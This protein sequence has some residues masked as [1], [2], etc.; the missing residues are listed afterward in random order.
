[1]F[2]NMPTVIP[3]DW[4]MRI[5]NINKPRNIIPSKYAYINCSKKQ[6]Y[7]T[8]KSILKN[9]KKINNKIGKKKNFHFSNIG[10]SSERILDLVEKILLGKN[11]DNVKIKP[12]YELKRYYFFIKQVTIFKNSFI[13]FLKKIYSIIRTL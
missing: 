1:M 10:Y 3:N 11:L 5:N 7:P 8:V 9:L 4:K 12:H 13:Q 2:F 6:L